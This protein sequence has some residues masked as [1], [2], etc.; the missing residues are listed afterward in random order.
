[1]L[2]REKWPLAY[3]LCF[4]DRIKIFLGL[5]SFLIYLFFINKFDNILSYFWVLNKNNNNK[6]K[7]KQKKICR[8]ITVIYIYIYII[9]TVKMFIHINGLR[10]WFCL[11]EP[12]SSLLKTSLLSLEL[13]S[14]V[15]DFLVMDQELEG[16][17]F[18]FNLK[19]VEFSWKLTFNCMEVLEEMAVERTGF[20]VSFCWWIIKTCCKSSS[21]MIAYIGD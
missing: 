21:K 8:L 20:I 17:M 4:T 14:L 1:M 10:I 13:V 3:L 5:C 12:M 16:C 11:A 6:K 19:I 2:G 18:K 7:T 15:S 9:I